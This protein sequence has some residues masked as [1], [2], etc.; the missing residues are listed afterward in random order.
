MGKST[1]R[2]LQRPI[3]SSVPAALLLAGRG[4]SSII[5]N[6]VCG[7][8]DSE[9]SCACGFTSDPYRLVK[10]SVQKGGWKVLYALQS[11]SE[12]LYYNWTFEV[13]SLCYI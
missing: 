6:S 11:P 8:E 13:R 7:W 1:H 10:L 9:G 5:M 12:V 2:P 3:Y 4:T